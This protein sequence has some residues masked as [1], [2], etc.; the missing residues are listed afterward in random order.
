MTMSSE[1]IAMLLIV[2][3]G[4]AR[5]LAFQ[6]LGEAKKGN[7][8]EAKKLMNASKEKTLEAHHVQTELLMAEANGEGPEVN[9]L[10]VHS[11]DHLMTSMLAQELIQ[12]LIEL[13]MRKADKT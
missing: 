10:L 6:A 7:F 8:E 3:S 9:I 13:N 4:D 1:E 12:E 11:Q 5:S 2:H